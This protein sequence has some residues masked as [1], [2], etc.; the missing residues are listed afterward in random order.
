MTNNPRLMKGAPAAAAAVAGGGALP[1]GDTTNGQPAWLVQWENHI[2]ARLERL[3]RGQWQQ[4]TRLEMDIELHPLEPKFSPKLLEC[5]QQEVALGQQLQQQRQQPGGS[6]GGGGG[7]AAD[8]KATGKRRAKI[9]A[10]VNKVMR[11][12]TTRFVQLVTD[13]NRSRWESLGIRHTRER[14]RFLRD[15]HEQINLVCRQLPL[16]ADAVLQNATLARRRHGERKEQAVAELAR[17]RQRQQQQA[18]AGDPPPLPGGGK[19]GALTLGVAESDDDALFAAEEER[20]REQVSEHWAAGERWNLEVAFGYQKSRVEAEFGHYLQ[21]IQNEYDTRRRSLL[22]NLSPT[23]KRKIVAASPGAGGANGAGGG[24]AQSSPAGP[25]KNK[26]KQGQLIH[27]APVFSPSEVGPL[28][29]KGAAATPS[30]IAAANAA[31]DA[32]AGVDA[33]ENVT[34][35]AELRQLDDQLVDA[36]RQVLQQQD[37]ALR[38]IQRQSMRMLLQL[39]G[40][41]EE[42]AVR[43]KWARAG[44]GEVRDLRALICSVRHTFAVLLAAQLQQQ[45]QQQ[46]QMANGKS[47][48]AP[49]LFPQLQQQ[50]QQQQLQQQQ[51]YGGGYQNQQQQMQQPHAMLMLSSSQSM[52]NIQAGGRQPPSTAPSHGVIASPGSFARAYG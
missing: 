28:S 19:A 6:S 7:A 16:P 35:V 48:S 50:Q 25:W 37:D 42:R 49:R 11:E 17:R 34:V 52:P 29:P 46:Q 39:E 15:V 18:S 36:K 23:A 24:A 27:T 10:Q 12:E 13:H 41:D 21:Q 14:K 32:A 20:M 38:W 33:A 43:E 5:L 3:R 51:Q 4:R 30:A 47:A 44:E 22:A 8:A 2:L 40:A 31:A 9:S 45:Q 26:E 1:G